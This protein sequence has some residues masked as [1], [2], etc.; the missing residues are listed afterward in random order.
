M[1][2]GSPCLHLS[3]KDRDHKQPP[4]EVLP[5]NPSHT[6]PA[7]LWHRAYSCAQASSAVC[8]CGRG[9]PAPRIL[10]TCPGILLSKRPCPERL[11]NGESYREAA[12]ECSCRHWQN[13]SAQMAPRAAEA[14]QTL[15]SC[16]Q[17]IQFFSPL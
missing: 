5:D 16:L 11:C 8:R 9:L 12:Q 7:Y 6:C 10:L 14:L 4:L 2:Q 1:P 13:L 3:G 15:R 17:A